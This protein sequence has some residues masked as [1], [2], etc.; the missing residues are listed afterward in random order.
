MSKTDKFKQ[1]L[2]SKSVESVDFD[3]AK[4]EWKLLKI[5]YSST[6]DFKCICG[7]HYIHKIVVIQN[8]LNNNILRIGKDCAANIMLYTIRED[9]FKIAQVREYLDSKNLKKIPSHYSSVI[10][11]FNKNIIT[12]WERQFLTSIVARLLVGRYITH[13]QMWC[14]HKLNNKLSTLI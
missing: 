3:K 4:I 12:N 5:E 2:L 8:T 10:I 6:R 13:R 1:A 14:L 7:Q 11:L 9:R